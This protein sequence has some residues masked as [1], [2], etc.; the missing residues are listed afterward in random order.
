VNVVWHEDVA[1]QFVTFAIEVL[2]SFGYDLADGWVF[3]VAIADSTVEPCFD[4]ICELFAVSNVN[5]VAPWFGVF[6]EEDL[7]LVFPLADFCERE[8]IG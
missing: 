4:L 5:F 2:K 7:A 8:G 1:V 6:V 3:Q